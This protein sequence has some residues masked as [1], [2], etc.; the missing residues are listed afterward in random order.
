MIK[1]LRIKNLALIDNVLVEFES[2]F[3]VFTGETGAGKSILIGAI[4]LL[5]GERASAEHIRSGSEEAEVSG[6]FELH[7]MQ[8]NLSDLFADNAITSEGGTC[9]V[10]RVIARSGKNRVFI[11]QVP[12][13]LS[14]L[15]T[16]GDQLIDF[17]GQHEHQSLLDPQNALRIVDRLPGVGKEVDGYNHAYA[18]YIKARDALSAHDR[19]CAEL[20]EKRDVIEFQYSELKNLGLS[21]DEESTLEEELALM[22]SS[23]Q[24]LEC[25]SA[26]NN[27]LTGGESAISNRIGTIKKNLESLSRFDP[28]ALPWIRDLDNAA[29]VF[30]ELESFC[31]EYLEKNETRV[32]PARLDRINDRL[33]KIQRLKKKYALG[34]F[35]GLLQKQRQLKGDLDALVNTEADRSVLQR[36]AASSLDECMKAGG[37]LSGARRKQ[38]AS[39][40]K[41]IT[42][43]MA[44]LGFLGG[45][46][47]TDF[48]AQ[49]GPQA[50]GLEDAAFSVRTNVGEPVLPLIKIA[51][52]GEI[53]RLMLAIKTVMASHDHIPILIFDEIDSGIG[54]VLAREVGRAL[55][56]LSATHQLLCISHLHQIASMADHHY[57]VYKETQGQRTVTQVKK[58]S[59]QEK[60]M[61]I[62]RMLGGDSAISKKHAQELLEKKQ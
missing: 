33:A 13:P 8:K 35:D 9:I 62:S 21:E 29:S 54:G 45:L 26:I 5:L 51:S 49:D 4:G 25:V 15:K 61:E 39:F 3:S 18:S 27:L 48:V 56:A 11:N 38:A 31:G 14:V 53:S 50:F 41:A 30:S 10:R 42:A 37:V 60:V 58:L 46:W 17:H 20:A 22:S 6:V 55:S 19:R 7:T 36:Q 28:S 12:V 34:G 57:H 2:G 40:D 16:V 1:E 44:K 43:E 47:R 32:D 59:H 23:A 24:R 52:G